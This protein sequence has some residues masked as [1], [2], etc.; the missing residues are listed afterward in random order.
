MKKLTAIVLALVLLTLTA[1]PAL[2]KTVYDPEKDHFV[3]V[4]S[5]TADSEIYVTTVTLRTLKTRVAK[6]YIYE[7]YW[8]RENSLQRVKTK[9]DLSTGKIFLLD[10][11][12][13]EPIGISWEY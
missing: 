2:A 7:I 4:C 1:A 12:T 9:T 5:E 13:D 6:T 8:M 11:E 10:F 3:I